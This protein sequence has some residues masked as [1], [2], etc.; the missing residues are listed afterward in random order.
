MDRISRR[1]VVQGA[2]AAAATTV[3]RSPAVHAQK[4]SS[5][6]WRRRI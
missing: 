3:L 5:A 2:V 4:G 6:S 1:Q